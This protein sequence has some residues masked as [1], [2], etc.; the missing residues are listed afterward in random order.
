MCGS[1]KKNHHSSLS[2]VTSGVGADIAAGVFDKLSSKP[3]KNDPQNSSSKKQKGNR[4]R[5]SNV[6]NEIEENSTRVLFSTNYEKKGLGNEDDDYDDDDDDD[7]LDSQK[8]EESFEF[9]GDDDPESCSDD[10]HIKYKDGDET[11]S[12]SSFKKQ[13]QRYQNDARDRSMIAPG[14]RQLRKE[15]NRRAA[16]MSRGRKKL[17]VEELQKSVHY[18]TETNSALNEQNNQLNDL[19]NQAQAYVKL[20]TGRRNANE[21]DSDKKQPAKR[22]KDNSPEVLVKKKNKSSSELSHPRINRVSLPPVGSSMDAMINFQLAA[23]ANM[24]IARQEIAALPSATASASLHLP[25]TDIHASRGINSMYQQPQHNDDVRSTFD[26]V[27]NDAASLESNTLLQSLLLVL[28]EGS[29][30]PQ[31]TRQDLT[32]L[33][34]S[35]SS[36]DLQN[37]QS[38]LLPRNPMVIADFSASSRALQQQQQQQQ[39]VQQ[40]QLQQLQ[41]FVQQE[42]RN[43]DHETSYLQIDRIKSALQNQLNAETILPLQQVLDIQNQLQDEMAIRQLQQQQQQLQSILRS[44]QQGILTDTQQL[45]RQLQQQIEHAE[46]IDRIMNHPPRREHER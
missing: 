20:M 9:N 7:D 15:Q 32:T 2:S 41:S 37:L 36:V 27:R 30:Q 8:K 11:S 18:F 21:N 10:Q 22:Y 40:G 5:R 25:T 38:L 3:K 29:K 43:R 1:N 31:P 34:H 46:Y 24:E 39:N 17:L 28:D 26:S 23:T 42:Q 4:K 19:L 45:Y 6:W 44:G 35:I 33:Q 13:K 12:T 14:K 16:V